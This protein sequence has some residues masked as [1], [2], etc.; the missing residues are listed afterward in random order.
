MTKTDTRRAKAPAK[1]KKAAVAEPSIAANAPGAPL[2]AP[3]TKLERLCILLRRPEGA[4]IE[5]LMEATGW[6]KHSVRGA[7]AGTLKKKRGLT[8]L[9]EKSDGALVYR[10]LARAAA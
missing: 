1:P 3:D 4:R 8:V 5:E 6:Q 9:S 7:M 10:I 2:V